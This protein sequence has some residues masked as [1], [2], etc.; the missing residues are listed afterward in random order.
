MPVEGSVE[1]VNQSLLDEPEQLTGD[2]AEDE[3]W[4]VEVKVID[5]DKVSAL[6]NEE[7]YHKYLENLDE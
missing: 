6:M 4:L 7:Q 1:S 5:G 2:S 3:G